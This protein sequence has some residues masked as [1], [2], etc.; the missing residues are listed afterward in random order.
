V[1]AEDTCRDLR[2]FV[3]EVAL[4]IADD[5]TRARVLAHANGCPE[6]RNELER[7]SV[8]V[9]EILS[10]AP[11]RQPSRGFQAHTL[12]ALQPPAAKALPP[13]RAR[14]AAVVLMAALLAAGSA[15]GATLLAVRHDRQLAAHYRAALSTAHGSAFGAVALHTPNGT[16]AGTVFAYRG[17]P[18]WAFITVDRE[19]QRLAARAA[20][21]TTSGRTVPLSSY[22][23]RAG[24]WGGILPLDPAKIQA[25]RLT[26]ADGRTVLVAYL[27]TSW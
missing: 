18:S 13:T 1:S 14:R 17:A 22:R 4:D 10:L 6:C 16:R 7:L 8:L 5:E 21:V 20:L 23:L 3:S 27:L 2:E 9:D 19:Y 24:N 12:R 15:T 25:L 11:E 26:S